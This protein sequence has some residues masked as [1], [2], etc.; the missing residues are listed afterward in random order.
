MIRYMHIRVLMET[1]AQVICKHGQTWE[2]GR[3]SWPISLLFFFLLL[4]CP[5]SVGEN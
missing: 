4:Y 3:D 5:H 2:R 1:Y